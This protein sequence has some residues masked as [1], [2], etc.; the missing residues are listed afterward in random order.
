VNGVITGAI[1][2]YASGKS[3]LTLRAAPRTTELGEAPLRNVFCRVSSPLAGD[4]GEP[5]GTF[6]ESLNVFWRVSSPLAGD[7]GEPLGTF[8]ES[9][10]SL[11]EP[12]YE[13]SLV[14]LRA[15][16]DA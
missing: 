3:D 11:D 14:P 5:L 2:S 10:R 9:L 12:L 6:A 4:S 13:L 16:V 15:V 8:T 1:G 7:S